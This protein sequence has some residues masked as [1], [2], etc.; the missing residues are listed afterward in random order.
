MGRP[1]LLAVPFGPWIFYSFWN[2]GYLI[3]RITGDQNEAEDAEYSCFIQWSTL[4]YK[5]QKAIIYKP[6][7]DQLYD[8]EG[9][10]KF[11]KE[12]I[13]T[14]PQRKTGMQLEPH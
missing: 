9:W 6:I 2:Q 13:S 8:Y 1:F 12:A 4:V 5:G 14:K 7:P 10:A 11:Y 3:R